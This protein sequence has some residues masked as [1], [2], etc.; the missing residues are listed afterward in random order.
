[1]YSAE[2]GSGGVALGIVM[3]CVHV[4]LRVSSVVLLPAG[5][6]GSSYAELENA[7]ELNQTHEGQVPAVRPAVDG[8]PF[9]VHIAGHRGQPLKNLWGIDKE[10]D[11]L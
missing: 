2:Y 8:N 5:D 7:R 10:N 9:H 3:R 6:G 11:S 1:M 4:S